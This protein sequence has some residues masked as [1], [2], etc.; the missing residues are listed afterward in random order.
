MKSKIHYVRL[1][2][3][4]STNNWAKAHARKLAEYP[5][6]CITAVEQT[7]GRGR[8]KRQWVSPRGQNIYATL[9]F[10]IPSGAPYLCNI[11]QLLAY[12][13]AK[14]LKD[15]GFPAQI[16]WP[17]D[18]LVQDKKIAGVLTETLPLDERTGVIAGIGINVNMEK[19][20]LEAIGQPATSLL[21]LSGKPWDLQVVL[22]LLL[23]QF[24]PHLELLKNEGFSAFQAPFES[25]LAYKGKEITCRDGDQTI[26][27]ICH[28]ITADGR[29]Q[30]LLPSGAFKS[31]TAGEVSP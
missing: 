11:G 19:E 7:A 20:S 30:I 14:I 5:I 27:G 25:L 16:K 13:C 18:I 10:T 2:S 3:V 8:F 26:K 29:L 31:V 22:D 6:A 24:L 15:K 12:S 28:S 1:D 21:M 9:F 4:D 23:D 17:N